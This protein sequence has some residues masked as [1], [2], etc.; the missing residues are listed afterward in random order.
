MKVKE[1]LTRERVLR[2]ATI[3]LFLWLLIV[4][5][6]LAAADVSIPTGSDYNYTY[7][8]TGSENFLCE[9]PTQNLTLNMTHGL[10][11]SKTGP[12]YKVVASCPAT[13][14]ESINSTKCVFSDDLDPGEDLRVQTAYCDLDIRVKE[15]AEDSGE[16]VDVDYTEHLEVEYT[17]DDIL[18]ITFGNETIATIDTREESLQRSRY[19]VEYTCPHTLDPDALADDDT[20]K[21]TCVDLLPRFTEHFVDTTDACLS[22]LTTATSINDEKDASEKSCL[23]ELN[24]L[25]SD[26]ASCES[27]KAAL[28]NELERVRTEVSTAQATVEELRGGRDTH[29]TWNVILAFVILG[30]L[31]LLWGGRE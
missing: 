15:A 18:R 23:E 17:G 8:G 14:N 21:S 20:I 10:N 16:T 3:I 6:Q 12:Y 13:T 4:T 25:A 11:V 2:A 31:Y 9:L 7:N 1:Y 5:A 29:R 30:M 28:N 22:S 26:K 19:R 24:T 27:S